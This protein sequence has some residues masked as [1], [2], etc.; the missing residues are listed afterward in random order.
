MMK[1]KTIIVCSLMAFSCS[2]IAE[3]KPGD[4]IKYRQ[5]AMMFMRWNVATIKM[6]LKA[7]PDVY[8]RQKVSAAASAIAGVANTD[9]HTLFAPG[10]EAG[11]GWKNTLARPELFA[12]PA[13]VTEKISALRKV[14]N[15]LALVTADGSM[16]ETQQQFDELFKA[17]QSCHKS[18]RNKPEP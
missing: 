10:T 9:L 18:Y 3:V 1:L 6:Q 14:A 17:C 12:E 2:A 8:D 5:S 16:A 7:N 11:V 4:L 15:K 13:Q